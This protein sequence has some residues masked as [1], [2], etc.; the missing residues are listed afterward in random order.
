[1]P[2]NGTQ[3]PAALLAVDEYYRPTHAREL[4]EKADRLE[5]CGD[6]LERWGMAGV[7]GGLGGSIL[8]SLAQIGLRPFGWPP[9]RPSLPIRILFG[10]FIICLIL[11]RVSEARLQPLARKLRI[12]A[13]RLEEEH[14]ARHGERP[15]A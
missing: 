10:S 6:R 1:M 9:D 4:R 14:Q 15:A 8:L 2:V 5:R 12:A 13:R 7:T 3:A 11:V